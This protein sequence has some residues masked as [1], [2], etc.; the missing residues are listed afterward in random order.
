MDIENLL[1]LLNEHKVKYV[2]VGATAFPVHG[3]SRVTLDVDIFIHATLKNAERTLNALKAAG[4]DVSDLTIDELLKK[5]VLFRQYIT[6]ADIHPHV[7]GVVFNEVWRRKVQDR[8]GKTKVYFASLS[9]LIKMKKAA[10]RP[11]DLEDLRVLEK[12]LERKKL[13]KR[14]RK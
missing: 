1:R 9:D 13:A 2:V 14:K 10:G 12:L 4:Y 6:E 7:K 8:I 11:K 5:K 3:F